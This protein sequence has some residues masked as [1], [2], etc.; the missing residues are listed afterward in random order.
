[1]TWT[2]RRIVTF[3]TV[4]IGILGAAL[5]LVLGM[6]YREN[7][8]EA[9]IA[10]A[11]AIAE[12]EGST[13]IALHYQNG[14]AQLDFVCD[15][16]GRWTWAADDDF[17]LDD[18]N[19]KAILDTLSTMTPHQIIE[20]VENPAVL[21][22]D[23]P[24]RS[25]TAVYDSGTEFTFSFGVTTPEGNSVYTIHNGEPA[26]VYIYSAEILRLMEL[27]VYDMCDLPDFP[28]I[29]RDRVQ[30]VT[31]Q[32]C[33]DETG[34]LP[35]FTMDATKREE[36]TIWKS[37]NITVTE[38]ARVQSLLEDL[39][40]MALASCVSYRPSAEAAALCG[41]TAPTATLWANY[42]STTDLEAHLQ[43]VIGTPTLDGTAHYVRLTDDPTIYSISDEAL[44]SI[45]TISQS[46]FRG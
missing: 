41:F 31:V 29:E 8:T 46:G 3:L 43:L 1:M 33:A 2:E 5:L 11:A 37:D 6:K 18:T 45:L 27:G 32:G 42:T 10:A 19:I 20:T 35:R 40:T 21:E 9:E 28:V 16:K 44:D 26:P 34:T 4:I 17:P 13:C 24:T 38:S 22:L 25:L 7:R 15:E 23:A 12:Q 14:T 30:R 39:E 36:N